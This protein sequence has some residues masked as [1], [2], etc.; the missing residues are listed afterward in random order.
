MGPQCP[1]IV[2]HLIYTHTKED[3]HILCLFQLSNSMGKHTDSIIL[4][5]LIK[6]LPQEDTNLISRYL[7]IATYLM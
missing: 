4:P 3:I 2:H 7:G 5:Q 1:I 6:I